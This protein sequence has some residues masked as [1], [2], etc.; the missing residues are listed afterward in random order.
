MVIKVVVV[1]T[2]GGGAV[3]AV[4][5]YE[6]DCRRWSR[7][8]DASTRRPRLSGIA[9]GA[10][11]PGRCARPCAPL[12]ASGRPCSCACVATR[13]VP[14]G[15]LRQAA[16]L[17]KDIHPHVA[18]SLIIQRLHRDAAAQHSAEPERRLVRLRVRLLVTSHQ[19]LRALRQV[20][21]LLRLDVRHPVALVTH[22][23]LIVTCKKL[24]RACPRQLRPL[25]RAK[26][27]DGARLIGDHEAGAV[28]VPPGVQELHRMLRQA[29]SQVKLSV[30][31]AAVIRRRRV[32]QEQGCRPAACGLLRCRRDRRGPRT[33]AP[34]VP[35]AH[36]AV[37]AGGQH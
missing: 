28:R 26:Q 23:G 15:A 19:Q 14:P 8:R 16:S 36:A 3:Q 10:G 12:A 29:A 17:G 34:Q 25:P 11:A 13:R 9:A 20:R 2:G 24:L 22:K 37:V 21:R 33:Q 4:V 1:V 7:S 27:V 6:N 35:D 32:F 31:N 18:Q 30:R 5:A